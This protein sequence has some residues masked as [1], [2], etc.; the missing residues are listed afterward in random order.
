MLDTKHLLGHNL[1]LY[2]LNN[3]V[4][5]YDPSGMWF[6][7]P[8]TQAQQALKQQIDQMMAIVNLINAAHA[9]IAEANAAVAAAK[10]AASTPVPGKVT[11]NFVPGP[12]GHTGVDFAQPSGTL[13]RAVHSGTV[14]DVYTNGKSRVDDNHYGNSVWLTGFD[15][16][17]EI[18]GHLDQVYV[19][20]G[21]DVGM[22]VTIGT[23]GN[24]GTVRGM[25]GN[26]LHLEV[27]VNGTAVN[28]KGYL[29]ARCYP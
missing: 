7:T 18:Y 23:V 25:T 27:R 3:P 9:L 8:E 29:P 20:V 26:H 6:T 16:V 22:Y 12:G 24:T 14:T 2:C 19:Q 4:N 1:Y 10:I 21:E 13:V 11:N 5:G 17:I 15:G 28:P